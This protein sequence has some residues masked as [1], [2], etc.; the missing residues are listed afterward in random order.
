M[1]C[2]QRSRDELSLLELW[3]LPCALYFISLGSGEGSGEEG[4]AQ[5]AGRL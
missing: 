2:W 4:E 5:Q 3:S 1:S